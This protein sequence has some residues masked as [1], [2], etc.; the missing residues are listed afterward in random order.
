MDTETSGTAIG[1]NDRFAAWMATP[2]GRG[3]RVVAGVA[4]IVIGLGVV[5]GI[6]GVILA[7]VGVVPILVG[8]LN[9]CLLAPILRTPF[10]GDDAQRRLAAR[11][12]K[13]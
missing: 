7:L 3:V 6:G 2:A 1:V 13:R 9:R 12:M 10:R 4:L 11:S 8:S 5:H